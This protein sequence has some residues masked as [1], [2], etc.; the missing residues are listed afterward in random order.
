MSSISSVPRVDPSTEPQRPPRPAPRWLR[1]GLVGLVLTVAVAGGY[2]LLTRSGP[3]A[4]PPI[5]IDKAGTVLRDQT[6]AYPI[7]IA[8]D[9]VSLRGVTIRTGGAA[10][11]TVR[12]G[13]D[14]FFVEDS[15]IRCTTA[16]TDGIVPGRYSA[17]KVR[18]HGCRRSFLRTD[19]APATVVDSERD[20]KPY[21]TA[22]ASGPARM[23][24]A[25]AEG[26]VAP[27]LPGVAAVP[28]TPLSYWPGPTT[29][30]VPAGTVLKNSGSLTLKK[31]GQVLTGLNITGCVSVFASN[32][33]I[34][35]S[36][37]T[38]SSP[39]Y[40]VRVYTG[41]T[42]LVLEDVEING[43]GNTSTSVCCDNY[44]LR[45]INAFNSIDGPRIGN[46][47]SIVDSWVHDLSRIT[48]SHNDTLQTTGGIGMLIQHNRLEPYNA[49][50]RDPMNACLMIGSTSAPTV[51]TLTV[52]DNYCDG[53]NYSIGIKANLVASMVAIRGNKF[54]RNY[55]FGIV[56]NTRLP[57]IAWNPTTNVW[58]DNG[59]PVPFS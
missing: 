53:G 49:V 46:S 6:I 17:L 50:L 33:K 37:I 34:M 48:G 47:S 8:A 1:A 2:L 28:P 51:T 39:T 57:G 36:R 5:V 59:L 40:S 41:A 24:F 13:V 42:K 7:E 52:Q 27:A 38:C 21:S 35:K 23:P 29:T 58:F 20:G 9:D 56:V 12:P 54:G 26:P 43:T 31:A 10:A 16:G 4:V 55:R 11:I 3:A 18:T 22:L 19:L 44:T 32:V 15:D 14:G 25:P 30:G 45:R